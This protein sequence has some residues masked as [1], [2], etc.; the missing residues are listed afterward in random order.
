MG[1]DWQD[2]RKVDGIACAGEFNLGYDDNLAVLNTAFAADQFAEAI[3]Y[4][5][6][7]YSAPHEI[8]LLLRFAVSAHLARGYEVLWDTSGSMAVVRWNGGVSDFTVLNGVDIGPA[9]D[10]D[11]LRAE[12]SGS[13]IR[14]LKN[15]VLRL[16]VSD[17]VWTDGQPGVSFF[18]RPGA[19]L[20][21]Y[22]WQAFEGG[23]L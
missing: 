5:E 16:T 21:A 23:S 6:A 7:G 15:G 11:V 20:T 19:T 10:G 2:A 9:V 4:R 14:V 22:G 8:E 17:L 13:V 3:V 18:A 12:I 1:I